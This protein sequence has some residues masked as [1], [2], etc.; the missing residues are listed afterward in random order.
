MI[1]GFLITKWIVREIVYYSESRGILTDINGSKV[2][3]I[4]LQVGQT[5]VDLNWP[6]L[7]INKFKGNFTSNK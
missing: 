6:T 3:E 2:I 4:L 1:T 7:I 5:N